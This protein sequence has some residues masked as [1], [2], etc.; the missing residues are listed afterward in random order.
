MEV[1]PDNPEVTQWKVGDRVAGAVHGGLYKDKGSFAEFIKVEPDLCF[2]V[3]ETRSMGNAAAYGVSCLTAMQALC[4]RLDFPWPYDD[5]ARAHETAR[6]SI[7]VYGGSTTA[8]LMTIQQAERAGYTVVATCSPRNFE[9]CQSYGASQCFDYNSPGAAE[10][11]KA[12]FPDCRLALDCIAEGGTCHF[13]VRAVAPFKG[14]VSHGEAKIVTL[15]PP[16]RA[17]GK[18]P[19]VKFISI[20]AYTL[21][22]KEFQRKSFKARFQ[23]LKNRIEVDQIFLTLCVMP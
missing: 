21:Q 10:R 17:L 16:P 3:P 5:S 1:L 13:C 22:G 4:L 15:L 19:N 7:L 14:D 20:M 23:R 9:L 2:R 12:A 8:G 6:P 11:I 18:T